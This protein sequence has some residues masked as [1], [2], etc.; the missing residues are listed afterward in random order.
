MSLH[1]SPY[2]WALAMQ[3][4]INVL[5]HPNVLIGLVVVSL[6]VVKLAPWIAYVLIEWR[7]SNRQH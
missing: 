3:A 7:R 5:R 6:A 1:F 2:E 4:L